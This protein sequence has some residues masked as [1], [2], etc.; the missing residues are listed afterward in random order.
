M[1]KGFTLIEL[2]V[3]VLIIGIL[4]AIALPQYTKTV[5]KSR[6][7]EAWVNLKAMDTALKMYRL[8]IAD[9][10]AAGSFEVLEIE[11]PGTDTTTSGVNRKNTKN[12]S[13]AF[14]SDHIAANRLPMSTKYSLTIHDTYGRVCIGYSEEGQK[15]CQS[16]GGIAMGA[17]FSSTTSAT[18]YQL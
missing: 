4:A 9:Q 13:Y 10:N 17:C 11:I 16:L 18:C 2:L 3:V 6:T 14:L 12:F 5:E 1:K 7:A 15:L 8:A